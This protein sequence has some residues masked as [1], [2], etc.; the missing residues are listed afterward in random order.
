MPSTKPT[1]VAAVFARSFG[2]SLMVNQLDPDGTSHDAGEVL[3][4][5]DECFW[6]ATP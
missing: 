3:Q 5:G 6:A 2:A 4:R 1:A